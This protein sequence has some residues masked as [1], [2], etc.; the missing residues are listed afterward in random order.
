MAYLLQGG[1]QAFKNDTRK[2]VVGLGS[3]K[4][5][6]SGKNLVPI[7]AALE[8]YEKTIQ[9]PLLPRQGALCSVIS[10]CRKWLDLKAAKVAATQDAEATVMRRRARVNELMNE[11]WQA[12]QASDGGAMADAFQAYQDR[13]ALGAHRT[14][15]LAP[16]YAPERDA[17]LNSGKTKSLSGSLIDDLLGTGRTRNT[18]V[19]PTKINVNNQLVDNPARPAFAAQNAARKEQIQKA[20]KRRELT[21]LTAADW[22]KIEKI[23]A[24]V[25]SGPG[26]IETKY[27]KRPERLQHML[28]SDG[29]GGLRYAIDGRSAATPGNAAWPYAMDEWGNIYTANDLAP[30]SRGG[31]AMFNHSS[32]TA[33]DEVVCAGMLQIGAGGKLRFIDNNSGHYKPTDDQIRAAITVLRDEYNVNLT[34][35]EVHTVNP[36]VTWGVGEVDRFMAGQPPLPRPNKPLPPLPH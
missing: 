16:G 13:K 24:T 22:Q 25:A 28:E 19:P 35:T 4:I 3:A 20:V 8:Y 23:A 14:A 26:E 15:G 7:I 9:G 6:V 27:M 34:L 33:G 5:R 32:F 29:Q 1:A 12:L 17:Y 2:T 10:K 31:Y 30:E 11:A 36:D 18:P 21:A